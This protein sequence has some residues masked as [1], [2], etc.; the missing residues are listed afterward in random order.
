LKDS[1]ILAESGIYLAFLC[2][3]RRQALSAGAWIEPEYQ[4]MFDGRNIIKEKKDD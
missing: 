2:V 3:A 4:K 1:S